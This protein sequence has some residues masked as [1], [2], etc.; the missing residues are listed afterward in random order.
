MDV[1]PDEIRGGSTVVVCTEESD[2]I[3]ADEI[4]DKVV[5]RLSDRFT[6]KLADVIV[7]KLVKRLKLHPK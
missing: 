2:E 1:V 7:E 4:A 5:G 6:D 3:L